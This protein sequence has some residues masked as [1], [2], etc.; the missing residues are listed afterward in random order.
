MRDR[1]KRLFDLTFACALLLFAGPLM[2]L[3]AYAVLL[4]MGRPVLFRQLRPGYRRAPF[5]ILKFRTMRE[6]TG[7]ARDDEARLTRV[8]AF[9]R[10]T[11]LD[12]LP[13]LFNVIRGEM[14]FVGPRPLLMEYLPLYSP[15]QDRRHGA[16]PGIT[17][18][19]Q[20]NGRN[21]IRWEEK[22]RLDAWYVDNRSL[23]LDI[24]IL[25]LTVLAAASGRG[26][27]QP[28]KATAEPFR[29]NGEE[30]RLPFSGK[31]V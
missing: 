3:T 15:E 21:A 27:R 1:L 13:E 23:A 6:G 18:W 8:G 5:T 11:S 29:G 14:S 19:A 24:R 22:F 9:L 7:E 10:R 30:K 26:V 17:G 20:V 4:S 28:G 2:L 25:L 12:E 16:L 31:Q